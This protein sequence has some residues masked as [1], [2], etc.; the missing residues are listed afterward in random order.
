MPKRF[1]KKK[2]NKVGKLMLTV[3]KISYTTTIIIMVGFGTEWKRR[4]IIWNSP[5][6]ERNTNIIIRIWTQKK[7]QEKVWMI[8][9]WWT[10][11]YRVSSLKL[12]NLVQ[13]FL[14]LS[15]HLLWVMPTNSQLV[16][17][18]NIRKQAQ[19][20]SGRISAPI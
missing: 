11:S 9:L 2:K 18:T 1:W 10:P 13:I 12:A 19:K 6:I 15:P 16:C 5:Q 4:S 14:S 7:K 17:L 8:H 20:T 3:F